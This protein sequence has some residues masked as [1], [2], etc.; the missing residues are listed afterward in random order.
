MILDELNESQRKAVVYEG[1]HLL[2]LAG[3]G[4]GKTKTIIARAV[5]LIS[6]GVSPSQIQILTFTR[7]AAS[8]I[9]SRVKAS[10]PPN[11]ANT[12][13]GSTFHSWC[14]QL[15][16]NFPNLFG[17]TSF[18]V[19]DEDDQVAIMKTICGKNK[20]EYESIRISPQD[21]IDI[22]SF[23][24][25]T[26]SNLTDTI[27]KKVIED[28]RLLSSTKEG[29][30]NLKNKLEI[31]FRNYE[32]KKKERRYL[33]YD[34]IIKIVAVRFRLDSKVKSIISGHFQHI[35]VDEFQDTNPLQW[36][37][38]SPLK[39]S[40]NLFCVGDDAQ[41]I[42]SF[43]GA[44]F[45]NIHNF[46]QN[47]PGSEIFKLENNYRS[48]QEILN[49]ANWVLNKSPLNYDKNL[50]SV[51][52][53]GNKPRLINV[54]SNWSEFYWIADH[55]I[56][57]ITERG[58]SYDDHLILSRS[59]F[60]T[61]ALQ[62]V[63]IEK[64]IPHRV[65]G[66]RGLMEAAH[67]RD[68]VSALRVVNNKD[69]EIAWIRYL[70]FWEGIGNVKATSL[71]T[72][73]LSL[74][75]IESCIKYLYDNTRLHYTISV[76]KTLEVIFDF[77]YQVD[78]AI[79]LAYDNL[80]KRF[81][82]KYKNDWETKRRPDFEVL[83]ILGS[84]Y[85]ALGHFITECTIDSFSKYTPQDDTSQTIKES[86]VSKPILHSNS[87]VTISTIHSAKGLESDICYVVDVSP[88]VY[89][90]HRS[91]PNFDKVEEDRRLLYVA[92]TRAKNELILTRSLG[93]NYAEN[94]KMDISDSSQSPQDSLSLMMEGYFLNGIP[95]NLV[96]QEVI[97]SETSLPKDIEEKNDLDIDYGMD[98]T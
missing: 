61:K 16:T 96:D 57:N 17:T 65:F 45:N 11:Q 87:L 39:D 9:V 74:T 90:H 54:E 19:I 51:R 37:L 78:K 92:L 94:L 79:E 59:G 72:T 49:L 62:A 83:E 27:Q 25:N 21:L 2:V 77:R 75:D 23:A 7:K 29:L 43:R 88:K 14:N 86:H 15:L 50:L 18:T 73:L 36:E 33:D 42:Y 41:S 32:E 52:G 93:F 84:K 3:A 76:S 81:S 71:L 47:V 97:Q 64:K 56:N 80:E 22:Y 20:I 63:F 91:V 1:K 60:Y 89:P 40:S 46:S 68:L 82:E 55:I 5:Y 38:L 44:D 70:T 58:K 69:D 95:E 4:T 10:L 85:T 6:K 66:G 8:E 53:G 48:T 30:E 35:L 67:I 26:N 34:D 12:L 28:H 13:G 24:R 31:L 98:F